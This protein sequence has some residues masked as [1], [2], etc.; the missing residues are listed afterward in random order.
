AAVVLEAFTVNT[1]ARIPLPDTGSLRS[2]LQEFLDASLQA[3]RARATEPIL[4]SLMAESLLDPAFAVQ[5]H[6]IFIQ[7]R[8]DSLAELLKRGQ[9][10]GELASDADIP[11]LLDLVYGA[12]WYRILVQHAILDETFMRHVLDMI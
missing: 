4:R 11:F 10:R 7:A 9:Q 3:G 1:A 6:R 2:D 8:R 5:F 12:I